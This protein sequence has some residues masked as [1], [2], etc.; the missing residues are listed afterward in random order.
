MSYSFAYTNFLFS[1]LSSWIEIE[2]GGAGKRIVGLN[3]S[4]T[5]TSFLFF[6]IGSKPDIIRAS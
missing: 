4:F 5:Y 6:S 1:L 3:Y 2:Q